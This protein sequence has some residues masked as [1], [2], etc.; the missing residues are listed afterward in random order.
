MQSRLRN[1]LSSLTIFERDRLSDILKYIG[2][3]LLVTV[4]FID[5][6]NWAANVAAGSHYGYKLL[7]MVTLSTL[8][9]VL[10]Q[11][12]AAHLGIATGDC[13]SEA[14]TRHLKPWLSRAMLASSMLAA[15]ATIMAELL[16]ASIALQILF[17]L[18]IKLGVFL[19]LLVVGWFLFGNSYRRLEKFIIGFVSLIGLAFLFEL[20]LVHIDWKE[21]TVGWILTSMPLGSLTIIMSVMGAVV[22]PH[23]LFL[24]SEIIQSRQW[25]VQDEAVI[26]HQLQ[27]EFLDTLF[28]MLIGW[29]INSA[30]ILVAAATFFQHSIHV[31]DLAQA[32]ATLR[33]LVGNAA[34]IVF[35]LALLFAGLAS[36]VTA[37]MAG[38]SIFSGIFGEPYH[39]QDIHTRMG[40]GLTLLTGTVVILFI[41]DPFEGL[42]LSQVALSIQL[43]WTIFLLIYLTSSR[44]VMG[45]HANGLLAKIGLGLIAGIVTILN[46]LLLLDIL[47]FHLLG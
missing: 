24:H 45:K 25:N 44:E 35:A 2:P 21:A 37:G 17:G 1:A 6:G 13:L 32:E 19:V 33:P 42:I 5:P 14:A 39:S 29:G 22:M 23:N 41:R 28:S 10:L 43:P 20:Y 34:S 3:G 7:W 9:L 4:G 18:P 47:G 30:M 36:S 12:N 16:G 38:G 40:I 15:G 27:Y 8:M 31:T 46:V 11:H 26:A